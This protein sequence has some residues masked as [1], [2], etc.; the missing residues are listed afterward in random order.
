M[1]F[2]FYLPP[3]AFKFAG[4]IDEEGAAFYAHEF[5]AV[6]IF[7]FDNFKYAAGLLLRN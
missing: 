2:D 3:L 6:H 4:R 5:A 1:A 7:L